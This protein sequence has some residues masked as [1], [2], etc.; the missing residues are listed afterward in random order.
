MHRILKD[1]GDARRSRYP[2]LDFRSVNE[3]SHGERGQRLAA[4]RFADKRH[5]SVLGNREADVSH[6]NGE[7]LLR[8]ER[9][10]QMLDFKDHHLSPMR[11]ERFVSSAIEN[12]TSSATDA[13][14]ESET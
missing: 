2:A 9:N 14:R 12:G 11:P 13:Q 8:P 5:T 3:A 7:S 1:I 10:A 4:A 6:G